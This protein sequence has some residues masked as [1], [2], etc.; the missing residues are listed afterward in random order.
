[1]CEQDV[2]RRGREAGSDVVMGMVLVGV[3]ALGVG[4]AVDEVFR[5]SLMMYADEL[6][7]RING[8]RMGAGCDVH[9]RL[10]V[11]VGL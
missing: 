4:S 5:M 7:I 8:G 10:C 9:V 3:V 2:L 6:C 1:M 11:C